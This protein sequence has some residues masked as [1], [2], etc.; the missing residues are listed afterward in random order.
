MTT[1]PRQNALPEPTL[2]DRLLELYLKQKNLII[3]AVVVV[4]LSAGGALF[5][6]QK[7][8]ADEAAASI[9]LSKALSMIKTGQMQA[10]VEGQGTVKGLKA[11]ADTWGNTPSGNLSRLYLATILFTNGK[12]D[13]ALEQYKAFS[14]KDNDLQAAAIAGVASCQV[15][16]KAFAAAAGEFEKAS[17]KAE[18]ETL[19]AMY[20]RQAAESEEAAGKLDKAVELSVRVIRTWPATSSAGLSR[21]TLLRLEGAGAQ[22]PQL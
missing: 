5:W 13:A 2:T 20:L 6:M 21:R 1:S 3:A 14:S 11:I 15:Q 18:N 17:D 7:N 8:K 19:K 9:A 22:V 12:T 16:K 4:C 10:A